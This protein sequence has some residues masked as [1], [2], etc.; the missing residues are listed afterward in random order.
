[1]ETPRGQLPE[2][3]DPREAMAIEKKKFSLHGWPGA[4]VSVRSFQQVNQLVF[5]LKNCL[6]AMFMWLMA[7]FLWLIDMPIMLLFGTR[8]VASFN[9][10]YLKVIYSTFSIINTGGS[11]M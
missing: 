2:A 10:S 1:M 11:S 9:D 4:S 3:K 6:A 5:E 8:Y 7:M